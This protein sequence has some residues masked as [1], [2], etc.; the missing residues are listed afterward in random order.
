MSIATLDSQIVQKGLLPCHCV[1]E[2]PLLLSMRH[3]RLLLE[4]PLLRAVQCD[5]SQ[6][7]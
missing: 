3:S 1:V 6:Y 2:Q 7:R 5:A 4:V